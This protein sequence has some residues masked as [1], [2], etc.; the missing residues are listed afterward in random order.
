MYEI[1]TT[2]T[3][4]GGAMV[5]TDLIGFWPTRISSF[6]FFA[7][8][9]AIYGLHEATTSVDLGPPVHQAAILARI[10]A[11]PWVMTTGLT[12][13]CRPPACI[14]HLANYTFF[15]SRRRA[16]GSS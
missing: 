8:R 15:A 11:K 13:F 12:G 14:P 10:G 7:R 4:A 16:Q 6:S 1:T 3:G 2:V 5:S 9:G